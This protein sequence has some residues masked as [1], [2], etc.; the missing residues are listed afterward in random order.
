MSEDFDLL[1]FFFS[2]AI[3][4]AL[5]YLR[6]YFRVNGFQKNDIIF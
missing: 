5:T 4:V 1:F 2:L 3:L 6:N